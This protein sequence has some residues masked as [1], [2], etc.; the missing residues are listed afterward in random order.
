MVD[1]GR[2]AQQSV[3]WSITC[4]GDVMRRSARLV[5]PAI[6]SALALAFSITAAPPHAAAERS[7]PDQQRQRDFTSAATEFGV[8]AD[9][10]LA[11]SYLESRW[12][13]HGGSPSTSAGYGPMHLT[14][15]LAANAGSHHSDGTEDPRGDD[16]RP[17]LLPTA[18]APAAIPPSLHT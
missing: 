1:E 5:P 17:A 9:V 18:T 10:L 2:I 3:P 7:A 14:D 13:T 4:L 11:V 8:P 6:A 12:D 15:A 16:A